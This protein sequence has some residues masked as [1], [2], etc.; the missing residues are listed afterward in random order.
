MQATYP[1]S[2]SSI[3]GLVIALGVAAVLILGMVGGFWLKSLAPVAT[4]TVTV[5]RVVPESSTG[6]SQ[7]LFG[8]DN[9]RGGNY[10]IGS[11]QGFF[12]SNNPLAPAGGAGA[13]ARNYAH[14]HTHGFTE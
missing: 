3:Q 8:S 4:R 7:G 9:P 13:A 1:V 5:T 11:S 14:P 2:R 12:G 10:G 6:S